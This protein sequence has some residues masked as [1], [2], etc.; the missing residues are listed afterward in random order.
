MITYKSITNIN[1][2]YNIKS[3]HIIFL[4]VLQNKE[5]LKDILLI[6]FSV[7]LDIFNLLK[8]MDDV[9]CIHFNDS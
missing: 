6:M 8:Y 1:L 9:I 7:N 3:R 2:F 4:G 5:D